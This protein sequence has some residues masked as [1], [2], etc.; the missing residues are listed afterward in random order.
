MRRN[1]LILISS[2]FVVFL[3][4]SFILG[5]YL[6]NRSIKNRQ[7]AEGEEIDQDNKTNIEIVREENRI[8]PNTLIEERIHY[9][10]CS[11]LI[12]NTYL[13][14]DEVV[15]LTRDEYETYLASNQPHLRL[16]AFS[17]VKVVLYGEKNHL[18]QEHYI[19]GEHNG[20]V[21]IYKIDEK[22]ERVLFKSFTD[23]PISLLI[24]LDQEK[25][26]EGIIVNSEEELSDI[27]EDFIS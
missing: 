20:Y 9:K 26:R 11:H 3:V 23:Y 2:F 1:R 17:N 16:V 18:C 27:L 12:T 15:N 21:A 5:Y 24:E 19:V 13:A 7:A 14:D 4:V 8:S 10:A 25:L 6:M 22:G